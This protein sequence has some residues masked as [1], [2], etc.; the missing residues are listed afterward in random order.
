MS[1]MDKKALR[2]QKKQEKARKKEESYYLASQWTL[3]GRKLKKHKLA[4]ISMVV[5]ILLYIGVI[6]AD[7]I[8]PYGL[9]AN[10]KAKDRAPTPVHLFHEGEFIGPFV[11]KTDYVDITKGMSAVEKAKLR[12]EAKARGEEFVAIQLVTDTSTPYPLRFLAKG[13]TYTWLGI[14]SDVHLFGTEVPEVGVYLFGTNSMGKD[15]FSLILLGS[16]V[17]LTIPFAGTA[18]SFVLGILL[19]SISGYFGGWVDNV[20]QRVIEVLNSL[21]SLPLWMA[22]SA[23]IPPNIPSA[24]MYLL[25]TIILSLLGWT[26]LARVVRGKFMSLKNADFVTAA[27]LAGVSDMRIIFRHLVPGFMSYLIVNL[28]LGIPGMI[29]GE[30]SMSFLGLGIQ[31]PATSWGVLLKDAQ[32]VTNIAKYPWTLIPLIFVVIAVLAFNFLGDGMRDA[33][34][35]YK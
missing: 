15:I 4:R 26:G 9:A 11:Y 31:A 12:N 17:S 16:R 13:S 34:D 8:A 27:R 24:Q 32:K 21:P 7:F 14:K 28:T 30:T 6:F 25:I 23:A 18:I 22:L 3:M 2:E 5:L 10:D 29:I 33:A 20:I 19:G 1:I 35:P